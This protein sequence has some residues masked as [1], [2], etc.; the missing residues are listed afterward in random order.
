VSVICNSAAS[1]EWSKAYQDGV[2]A[3]WPAGEQRATAEMAN[4][5]G[6]MQGQIGLQ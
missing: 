3:Y 4:E 2:A 6:C 1:I 5:R